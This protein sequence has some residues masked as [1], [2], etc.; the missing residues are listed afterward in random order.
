MTLVFLNDANAPLQ[1]IKRV[2]EREAGRDDELRDLLFAHPA[3]LPV[4]EID[5][6]IGPLVPIARE[7]NVPEVSRIDDGPIKANLWTVS[8][9][10]TAAGEFASCNAVT[11]PSSIFTANRLPVR[12]SG[13]TTQDAGF[14]LAGIREVATKVTAACG[15]QLGAP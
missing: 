1:I 3:M 4:S 14:E 5:P 7:P 2:P 8:N 15:I 11:L 12:L 9:T 13:Q 10:G 6:G